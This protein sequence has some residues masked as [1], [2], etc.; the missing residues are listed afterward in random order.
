MSRLQ[1]IATLSLD[2]VSEG[3]TKDHYLTFQ[4]MDSRASMECTKE[5]ALLDSKDGE[6][7]VRVF[8]KYVKAAFKN[9]KVLV[10]GET[11]DAESDDIDDLPA[12]LTTSAFELI[13][14]SK[15]DDPKVGMNLTQTGPTN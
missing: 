9:G 12:I 11:L 3:W 10:G 7:Y 4:V 1:L 13:T 8:T 5:M 14:R 6:A 2:R 15:Y